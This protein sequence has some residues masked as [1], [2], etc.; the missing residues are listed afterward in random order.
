MPTRGPTGQDKEDRDEELF[1]ATDTVAI[2]P[3]LVSPA[4]GDSG[5]KGNRKGGGGSTT[6][7]T[8][9]IALGGYS[10]CYLGDEIGFEDQRRR[11]GRPDGGH[12]CYQDV[13]GDGIHACPNDAGDMVYVQ[14]DH[15]AVEFVLRGGSSQWRTNG[16]A[17]IGTLS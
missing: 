3:L 4:F 15:P 12:V 7:V 13:N 1:V 16:G 6:S 11:T 14:L 17:A 2:F 9:S 8:S 5:G 10:E